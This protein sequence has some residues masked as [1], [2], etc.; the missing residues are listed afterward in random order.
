MLDFLA[1]ALGNDLVYHV[2]NGGNIDFTPGIE[3]APPIKSVVVI[4]ILDCH[5]INCFTH[6]DHPPDLVSKKTDEGVC[7]I[8]A[9]FEWLPDSKEKG[10][11][12]GASV[13]KGLGGWHRGDT[14]PN[15]W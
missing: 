11:C 14:K 10:F 15:I 9:F 12:N 8:N 3:T 5:N 4:G 6:D 13:T 7:M 2:L 1:A